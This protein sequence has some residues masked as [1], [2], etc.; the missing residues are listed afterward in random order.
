MRL[1][2]KFKIGLR[3]WKTV[4]AVFIC[5]LLGLIRNG[6]IPFYSMIAAVRCMD[7]DVSGTKQQGKDQILATLI[8]GF[9]GV[10]YIFIGQMCHLERESILRGLVISLMLAPLIKTSVLLEKSNTSYVGCVVF[11]SIAV[12]HVFDHNPYLFALNRIM[13]TLV[14]VI[15]AYIINRLLPKPKLDNNKC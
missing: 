8:G 12:I 9:W 5:Y 3:I 14:G 2:G 1:L 7:K 11:L 15:M 6:S 13:D 4:I 10:I